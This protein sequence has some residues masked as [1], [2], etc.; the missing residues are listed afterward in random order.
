LAIPTPFAKITEALG[1][2]LRRGE[3]CALSGPT[4]HGKSIVGDMW[5]DAAEAKGL[6]CHLYMTEMT[7]VI[8]GMRVMARRTGVPFMRQR[9]RRELTDADRS[10]LLTELQ[11]IVADWSID[12]IVRDALRA[13]YDFVVIDLLHGF[14]Y[15][16]ERGL[17]R[18]S[19]AVQK[20]ARVSTTLNGH[21]G[22][23]VVAITHLKEEGVKNGKI[24]RPNISSIKGGSSLKQDCDFVMFCWQD[25]DE[26]GVTNGDG[27]VWLAKGRS[28]EK[29]LVKV[30]LNPRRFRFE[31]RLEDES[32]EAEVAGGKEMPF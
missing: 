28:G 27:E 1:D 8:R 4:E 31:T 23:A 29:E 21:P 6:N 32:L 16:D 20:L 15:E 14:H 11:T 30:R 10:K 5:L 22:T 2:G 24:P 7:A 13:R 12:D 25:Q 26:R 9:R 17:D 3:S 19:K 18:L